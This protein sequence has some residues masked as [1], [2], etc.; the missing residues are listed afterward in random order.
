MDGEPHFRKHPR[1]ET[2]AL[3]KYR[4]PRGPWSISQLVDISETG[5]CVNAGTSVTIGTSLEFELHFPTAFGKPV[6]ATG[7][8]R[9][10]DTVRQHLLFHW[11]IEFTSVD[12]ESLA[13]I[14]KFIDLKLKDTEIPAANV[15][16]HTP[17]EAALE[18]PERDQVEKEHKWHPSFSE[19]QV[20][21]IFNL[22]QESGQT[23][24][25]MLSCNIGSSFYD[26]QNNKHYARVSGL[27]L[28]RIFFF[29][30]E[31]FD[32]DG[33]ISLVIDLPHGPGDCRLPLVIKDT[34]SPSRLGW[35][36]YE[37][38]I[39]N[40]ANVEKGHFFQLII[41]ELIQHYGHD[42]VNALMKES[43][44]K[45]KPEEEEGQDSP[46]EKRLWERFD[47]R[48]AA[49][50]FDEVIFSIENTQIE[51]IAIG[52]AR[53]ICH[54]NLVPFSKV[55][56]QLDLLGSAM[57]MPAKVCWNRER[58]EGAEYEVGLHF[59]PRN[60]EEHQLLENFVRVQR[61]KGAATAK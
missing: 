45:L 31:R 61:E 18:L 41:I 27:G 4:T 47:I 38:E 22:L 34:S 56:V 3:V 49:I 60:D 35:F 21:Y 37:T 9:G 25:G 57:Q 13:E 19:E 2:H 51:D 42:K 58:K 24:R 30:Q 33:E 53:M 46:K 11:H 23:R 10:Y 29:C 26:D 39:C 54:H 28:E 55:M 7:T 16:G 43:Q 17:P 5:M 50:L 15:D 1:Y 48:L 52:G 44:Q 8:V 12:G 59:L 20:K 6:L 14:R 40:L 36:G 32:I